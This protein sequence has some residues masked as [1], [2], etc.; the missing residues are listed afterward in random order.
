MTTGK[1]ISP[2]KFEHL[3]GV[4]LDAI[5]SS[6][7]LLD[8]GFHITSANRNFLERSQRSEATTLGRPVT[9][10][11]P[12]VL[13]EHTDIEARIREVFRS[14]QPLR[15]ERMTYRAPGISTRIYYYSVLPITLHERTDHVMLLME[16]VTKQVRLSE[17]VRLTERHLA[18]VVESASDIVLSTDTES[19]I[20]T[21]NL[22]AEQ[23]SGRPLREVRGRHFFELC[24]AEQQ[25]EAH[26]VFT[27][28]KRG[29]DSLTADWPLLDNRSEGIPVS[30]I[31]SPMRDDYGQT[32]GI[33][34]VG[35]DLTEQR[36]LE[37]ELRQSQKLAAL[38]VMAGGIAHEIRNP[39][40]VC[41]S[42]SQFLIEEDIPPEFHTECAQKIQAGVQK[43]STIIENLLR[44]ARPSPDAEMVEM[45]L[46][47]VLRESLA[48]IANQA[49]VKRIRVRHSLDGCSAQVRGIPS[50]LQQV[51]MNLFLN[52]ISAMP[53]GGTLSLTME[54]VENEVAMKVS[55]TGS[56]IP[57]AELDKVFDPFQTTSPVGQG[58]GL[59]LSICYTIIQQHLGSI[60][61]VSTPGEGTT[62]TV[63]LP[64]L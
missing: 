48:L 23:L 33:V 24:A 17:E 5:P 28:M 10:V 43:A 32:M 20:L 40:A 18:S 57:E 41:A 47:A 25:Q 58:T 38:G 46:T 42:A 54:T 21:W 4:L 64:L 2:E 3:Y 62:F 35:R 36:K 27:R 19:R 12:P 50:L 7:L 44:F 6:M 1:A 13:L 52:A 30:W 15:G 37:N 51:F 22:A 53:D 63:R 31:F 8:R 14:D 29:S 59:G 11:V 9:E 61:V 34:G 26:E 56:G 55:D 45:D 39:L 60:T 16:D 49:N